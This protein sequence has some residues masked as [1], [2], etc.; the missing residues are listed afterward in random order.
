MSM[1]QRLL[2]KIVPNTGKAVPIDGSI[3]EIITREFADLPPQYLDK[4]PITGNVYEAQKSDV[5]ESGLRGRTP[6]VELFTVD[7]ELE[8]I[9]LKKPTDN[10]IYDYVRK[11]Q[12]MLTMKNDAIL[13]CMAGIIPWSEVNEL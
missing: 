2:Q 12:G 5:S 1:A 11:T 10:E 13:K 6:A 8:N 4:L 9:I 3:E 7:K